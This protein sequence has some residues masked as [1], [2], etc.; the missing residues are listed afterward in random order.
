MLVPMRTC[1]PRQELPELDSIALQTRRVFEEHLWKKNIFRRCSSQTLN[2]PRGWVNWRDS[3][4]S[5]GLGE[6][7]RL[8]V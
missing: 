5:E 6:L 2:F 8:T 1:C 7:E 4:L 3:Q